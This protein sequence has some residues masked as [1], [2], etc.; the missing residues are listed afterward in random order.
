MEV[1]L[2]TWAIFG[3]GWA[4]VNALIVRHFRRENA[5]LEDLN[6]ALDKRGDEYR[7]KLW[8]T[9]A[10]LRAAEDAP[11]KNRARWMESEEKFLAADKRVKELEAELSA[12]LSA[13]DEWIARYS[14]LERLHDSARADA[15]GL[16]CRI[17]RTVRDLSAVLDATRRRS[18]PPPEKEKE[19]A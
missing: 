16:W 12:A 3:T 9:E 17:D 1:F 19:S 7:D 11:H 14:E 18:P 5:E 8:A 15:D 13:T 2:L 4:V 6:T 10:K